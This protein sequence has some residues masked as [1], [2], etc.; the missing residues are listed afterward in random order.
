MQGVQ[1]QD[2]QGGFEDWDDNQCGHTVW[3]PPDWHGLAPL[4][5][6]LE[7]WPAGPRLVQLFRYLQLTASGQAGTARH[8]YWEALVAEYGRGSD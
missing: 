5:L 7:S 3:R 4:F 2:Y 8:H 6:L 1:L